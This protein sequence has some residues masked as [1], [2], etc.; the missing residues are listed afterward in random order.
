MFRITSRL[1]TVGWNKYRVVPAFSDCRVAETARCLFQRT[2]HRIRLSGSIS[3]TFLSTLKLRSVTLLANQKRNQ[4]IVRALGRGRAQY[5]ENVF[6]VPDS[7]KPLLSERLWQRLAG[8]RMHL[9]RH[10]ADN[11]HVF[12]NICRLWTSRIP[13]EIN[14]L[15]PSSAVKQFRRCR[16]ESLAFAALKAGDEDGKRNFRQLVLDQRLRDPNP[17]VGCRCQG[18]QLNKCKNRG[19]IG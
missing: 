13:G 12:G 9:Q 19:I 7:C 8:V 5:L 11:E 16:V 17:T 18:R 1:L 2:T 15:L 4:G 10:P 14:R 6:P 3:D